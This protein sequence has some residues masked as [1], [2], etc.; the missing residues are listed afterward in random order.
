MG[1]TPASL[2]FSGS[3]GYGQLMKDLTMLSRLTDSGSLE[4]QWRGKSTTGNDYLLPGLE[5]AGLQLIGVQWLGGNSLNRNCPPILNDD[6]VDFG[7]AGKIKV[8][9]DRACS[10]NICMRTVTSSASLYHFI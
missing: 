7:I 1:S 5:G 2:S 8:V 6:L 4:D 9:V 3:P 10:M